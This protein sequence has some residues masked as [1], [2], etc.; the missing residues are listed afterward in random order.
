[1]TTQAVSVMSFQNGSTH[2]NGS[3]SENS[4]QPVIV[5]LDAVP[6]T[7]DNQLRIVE[8]VRRLNRA[9]EESGTPLRL[10]LL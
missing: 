4:T 8:R 6:A 10:R 2:R 5:R 3:G 9:L 1:M 7:A